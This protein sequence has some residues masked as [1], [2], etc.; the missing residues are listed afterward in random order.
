MCKGWAGNR[1]HEQ[2][3]ML[4][5]PFRLTYFSTRNS[6]TQVSASNP[7]LLFHCSCHGAQDRRRK[8][9]ERSAG[10]RCSEFTRALSAFW[11]HNW[12]SESTQKCHSDRQPAFT[13]SL[14][15]RFV[16][17]NLVRAETWVFI[18]PLP[19]MF[20]VFCF[21]G[22]PVLRLHCSSAIFIFMLMLRTGSV[23][24]LSC[25]RFW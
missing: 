24:K 18:C 9:G 16:H 20:T 1:Y 3:A 5:V 23:L 4:S 22:T 12:T 2:H 19:A 14:R 17:S 11:S 10:T 7:V 13:L 25:Q 6:S 15:W 8:R 21:D